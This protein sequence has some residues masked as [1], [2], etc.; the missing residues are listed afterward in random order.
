MPGSIEMEK[1]CCKANKKRR[2]RFVILA[3]I[4]L[5]VIFYSAFWYIMAGKVQDQVSATLQLTEQYG[6]KVRCENLHK[7]GYPL[8][9]AMACDTLT[10]SRPLFGVYFA[11]KLFVAGAPVYA[12][13]WI[14]LDIAAPV[15]LEL[16][17]LKPMKGEWKGLR[18]EAD[19]GGSELDNIAVAVDGL[20]I[21]NVTAAGQSKPVAAEFVR[22]DADKRD[23]MLNI[24]L[25]FDRLQIPFLLKQSGRAVPAMNGMVELALDH[26]DR[27]QEQV[28]GSLIK[29]IRGHSGN[30]SKAVFN[31]ESGGRLAVSGPFS[32]SEDG[33]LSARLTV[34]VGDSAA[35]MRTVRTLFPEQA[36]NLETLFFAL[37]SMPKNEKSE[38]QL[39]F[40]ITDG[41][42]RMGFIKL[43]RIP[44]LREE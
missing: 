37:N 17:G 28:G 25:S 22:L 18:L 11:S 36:D 23:D 3:I 24:R 10:W 19:L 40:D 16:P 7:T 9:I 43:G 42:A 1:H 21:R 30:L 27:F 5:L 15:T 12:P 39:V 14:S 31:M 8:R 29:Q 4:A 13:H 20:Q 32:V 35:M 41:K 44:P 26:A 38:P 33:L 2:K 34:A 6:I